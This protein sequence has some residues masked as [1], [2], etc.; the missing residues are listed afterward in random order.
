M[1]YL[2]PLIPYIAAAVGAVGAVR[3][4]NIAAGEKRTAAQIAEQQAETVQQQT[5]AREE[6]HRSGVRRLIGDQ[7]AVGAESGL[8]LSGSRADILEQS[9]YNAELDALNIRYEGKLTASGLKTQ[10]EFDRFSADQAQTSGYLNAASSLLKGSS[11]YLNKGGTIPYGSSSTVG[12]MAP[13]YGINASA[14]NVG[15][16]Y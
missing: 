15:M 3:Q 13:G 7:L 1:A 5:V 9:L 2:V 12:T 11:G 14:S 6:V 10:A 16:G 4:G 8:A